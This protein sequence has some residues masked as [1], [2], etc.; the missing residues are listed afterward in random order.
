M[1]YGGVRNNNFIYKPHRRTPKHKVQKMDIDINL[2]SRSLSHGDWCLCYNLIKN[3]DSVTYAE[4]LQMMT[5][6]LRS[7]NPPSIPLTLLNT[8]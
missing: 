5:E 6:L 8:F 7:A 3:M 2:I 4:W 1:D